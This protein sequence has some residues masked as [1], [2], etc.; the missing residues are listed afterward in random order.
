MCRGQ[1]AL[2]VINDHFWVL[3]Y[4]PESEVARDTQGLLDATRPNLRMPAE[5][6]SSTGILAWNTYA[7]AER[8][9]LE[10]KSSYMSSSSTSVRVAVFTDLW[11]VDGRNPNAGLTVFRHFDSAS[12]IRGLAGEQPQT[13]LLMGYPRSNAC[14]IRWWPVF[15]TPSVTPGT[16]S[17]PAC[18]WTFCAWRAR[19]TFSPYCP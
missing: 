15:W 9:Y 18:I 17:P 16:N 11:N 12:V 10:T 1:V 4:S 14:T 2:N 3:F 8:R 5:D 6:D 7:R 13:V 19:R